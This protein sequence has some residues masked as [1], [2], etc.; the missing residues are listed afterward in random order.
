MQALLNRCQTGCGTVAAV[1]TERPARRRR[2]DVDARRQE[3]L[4]L[5]MELF[6]T[7]AYDEV[8]IEEIAERAGIS[9]GLLYH[10]FPTKRD[11]Y[12]AVTT[13]AV[14]E[15]GR[16]TEPRAGADAMA[17]VVAGVEAYLAYAETHAHGFLTAHRGALA[18][19]AEVRALVQQSRRRQAARILAVMA[20]EGRPAPLTRLA[21]QG[22]IALAQEATVQW[23]QQRR[24]SRAALAEWLV[25][26][27]RC[28]LAA[29]D[30]PERRR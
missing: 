28:A 10:Y 27:L 18:G 11:F 20:R 23:L 29:A 14:E 2:L 3:L 13:Q 21:V 12:L 16:L 22:W 4:Q 15:I 30:S 26:T 25:S 8:G 5:G 17:N 1:R 9:R 24:P 19:D 7:R 6:S